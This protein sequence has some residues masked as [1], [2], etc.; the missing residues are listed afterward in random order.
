MVASWA[1]IAKP[2][3]WDLLGE[4]LALAR[5]DEETERWPNAIGGLLLLD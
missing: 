4:L 2:F 1:F 3:N 5:V